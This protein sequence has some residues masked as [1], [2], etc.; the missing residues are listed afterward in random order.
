MTV[1][2]VVLIIIALVL[3][4]LAERPSVRMSRGWRVTRLPEHEKAERRWM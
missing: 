4:R 3:A 1:A 2:L